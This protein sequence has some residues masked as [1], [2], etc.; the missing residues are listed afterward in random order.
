MGSQSPESQLKE[1]VQLPKSVM[2]QIKKL[3]H[4]S[5]LPHS[6]FLPLSNTV[7]SVLI[8]T[9]I[10]SGVYILSISGQS[11]AP[12]EKTLSADTAQPY[13]D[14]ERRVF[15]LVNDERKKLGIQPLLWNE[16]AAAAARSH[17]DDMASSNYLG[18]SDLFGGKPEDRVEK[19]G[20]TDWRR[21]GE[22]IAWVSGHPDPLSRV[23][24]CW[25]NSAGHRQNMLDPKFRESGLGMT[26]TSDG[27]SYFTQVFV[28]R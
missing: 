26:I 2:K 18:H 7:L 23:V 1:I 17:S 5:F 13:L 20:L 28:S 19:A 8:Y 27:K 21:L 16:K 15:D 22:N 11:V 4:L 9:T 24:E 12:P 6:K 25:M 3:S 10:V 14:S